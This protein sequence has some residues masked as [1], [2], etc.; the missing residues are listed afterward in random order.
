MSKKIL[1]SVLA[2][3]IA[4]GL[5]GVGTYAWWTDS[6]SA[7][8]EFCSG[9]FRLVV[10]GHHDSVAPVMFRDLAPGVCVPK[11][12][13]LKNDSTVDGVV[14]VSGNFTDDPGQSLST[15]LQVDSVTVD[16]GVNVLPAPVLLSNLNG[17]TNTIPIAAGETKTI[18]VSVCMPGTTTGHQDEHTTGN[19]VFTM[20]QVQT[21]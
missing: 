21:P 1:M 8:S 17:Q 7:T 5:V 12:V 3:T 14:T 11:Q 6:V 10:N 15:V 19:F 18:V 9:H 16:G 20:D 4:V 13:T 2:L